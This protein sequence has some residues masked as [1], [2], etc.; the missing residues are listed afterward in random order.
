M[1]PNKVPVLEKFSWQIPVETRAL[2]VPPTES[3]KG[4]RYI[5]AEDAEGAWEGQESNIAL[6][7][8]SGWEFI[9]VT[10]G[11]ICWVKDE[12]LFYK[13][14]G[15]AWTSLTAQS[16]LFE[17]DGDG[18]LMPIVDVVEDTYYELDGNNDIMP[19]A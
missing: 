5:V 13:F 9:A 8:G 16:A 1:N 17:L 10:E 2:S 15:I 6:Y 12:D 7:T 14:S 3:N 11:M 4:E 19:K 18:G